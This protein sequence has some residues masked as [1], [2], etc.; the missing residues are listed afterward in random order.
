[1]E[2]TDQLEEREVF[3]D[4]EAELPS[5]M[6]HVGYRTLKMRTVV[7]GRG[8]ENQKGDFVVRTVLKTIRHEVE[9]EGW[10]KPETPRGVD[11]G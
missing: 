11:L 9:P 4:W 10:S 2:A 1:M 7:L 3:Y 5:G 8:L 6:W